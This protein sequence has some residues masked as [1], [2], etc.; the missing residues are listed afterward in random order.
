MIRFRDIIKGSALHSRLLSISDESSSDWARSLGKNDFRHSQ[1]IEVI[2]DRLVPDRI[3]QDK[4]SFNHGEIFCLLVA[5]Y[6]HD[7][8]RARTGP[9]HELVSRELILENPHKYRLKDQYEAEAISQ[10][11]AAHGP[12][13]DWPLLNCDMAFGLMELSPYRP[14]NL[15]RLGALLRIADEL[16]N[17]Y[18]RVRGIPDQ[19]KSPRHLITDIEPLSDRLVIQLHAHPNSWADWNKL[20][21]I[22]QFTEK[23]VR[24][25]SQYLSDI[26]LDYYQVWLKPEG[27]AAPYHAPQSEIAYDNLVEVVAGLFESKGYQLSLMPEI[28]GMELSLLCEVTQI[29]VSRKIGIIAAT[30]LD[31]PRAHEIAGALSY[32][33]ARGEIDS[34]MTIVDKTLADPIEALF[35]EKRIHVH[36]V[37]DLIASESG[38]HDAVLHAYSSQQLGTNLFVKPKLRLEDSDAENDAIET[39]TDWIEAAEGVHMTVLGE[40]GAGKTTLS[41]YLVRQLAERWLENP[42]NNRIPI[43]IDLKRMSAHSSIESV[44]SDYM[45]NELGIPM[46]FKTF[47]SLARAGAF[48]IFLDGFDEIVGIHSDVSMIQAFRQIDRLSTPKGKLVLT[49]RTHLFKDN[50]QIHQI[51]KGSELY[52]TVLDKFGYSIAYLQPF[53]DE[54]VLEY[55]EKWDSEAAQSCGEMISTIYNLKDLASRPVLLEMIVKT[56]PQLAR[57]ESLHLNATTLYETYVSF[58]L[59]RDDWRAIMTIEERAALAES[60]A[61]HLLNSDEQL[62]SYKDIPAIIEAIG[63]DHDRVGIEGIDYEL[64]TCNFLKS[65]ADGWFGFV[66]KSFQEFFLARRYVNELF[67]RPG[68]PSVNWTLPM[69]NRQPHSPAFVVVPEVEDFVIQ[70]AEKQI[71]ESDQRHLEK[72]TRT[73]K[74]GLDVLA[75][76]VMKVSQTRFGL[77]YAGMFWRSSVARE[78]KDWAS[79]VWQS[80]NSYIT[81]NEI[82]ERIRVEIDEHKLAKKIEWLL[83]TAPDGEDEH[84]NQLVTLQMEREIEL[85]TGIDGVAVKD[86]PFSAKKLAEELKIR[87][88][89]VNAADMKRVRDRVLREWYRKKDEYS[90]K[91][92]KQKRQASQFQDVELP[93]KDRDRRHRKK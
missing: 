47:E 12:E 38:F 33:V 39:I 50:N 23:R 67:N 45:V 36:R 55:L 41:R 2:L 83:S 64:R 87:L 74:R 77:F 24:Y 86:Y 34:G 80:E 5:V 10:V 81:L 30:D 18:L 52:E 79:R 49:S 73:L 20:E 84:V 53:S 89:G 44:I 11:C 22:R 66:H 35:K 59:N 42:S 4:D 27:F 16:E 90:K 91:I 56:L 6:L 48:A 62:I 78:G 28:E 26:G 61:E 29:G 57:V 82:Y 58:W 72:L 93:R 8:G 15:R 60:L 40:F 88:H 46:S 63:V 1:N 71:N 92:R 25:A 14:L 32:L 68:G 76:S 65:T 17:S 51:H 37:Q 70:C 75:S 54:Q 85:P 69:E 43:L 9:G 7:I 21:N 3:K 13:S 31:L 19:A